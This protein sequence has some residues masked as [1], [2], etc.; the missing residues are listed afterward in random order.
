MDLGECFID[1]G[2]MD[3]RGQ[4]KAWISEEATLMVFVITCVV[5]LQLTQLHVLHC[6]APYCIVSFNR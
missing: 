4:S 1:L 2:M 3:A 5:K 6:I